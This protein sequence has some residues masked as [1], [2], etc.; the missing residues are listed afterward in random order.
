MKLPI[1]NEIPYPL[2]ILFSILLGL[3]PF[4]PE[5]HLFEKI[6]M[7]FKGTLSRPVDI[8]DL[9]FHLFPGI[10]LLLKLFGKDPP[11]KGA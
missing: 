4:V 3:A 5:P 6:R 11:Q 7:L 1:L 10:L 9:L 8:F 2:L